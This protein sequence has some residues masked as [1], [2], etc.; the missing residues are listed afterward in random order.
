M[1]EKILSKINSSTFILNANE[2][3]TGIV[4]NVIKYDTI[5]ITINADVD[6]NVNGIE[7]Y[8]GPS[9]TN[10]YLINTYSYTA[11]ENKVIN[12]KSNYSYFKIIYRN[13]G[14]PQT[15]FYLQTFYGYSKI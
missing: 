14:N 1:T 12:V 5:T 15:L 13:G 11:N 7:L 3:Y 2:V 10:L 6:S 4:E 9:S 8:C